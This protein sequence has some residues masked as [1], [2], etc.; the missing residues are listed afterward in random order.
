MAHRVKLVRACGVR[1]VSCGCFGIVARFPPPR[2]HEVSM[3]SK[4]TP[5]AAGSAKAV[6][7][8][9]VKRAKREAEAQLR[10]RG[11]QPV[12]EVTS[13]GPATGVVE[14]FTRRSVA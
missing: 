7:R 13:L 10:R 8:R 11:W 1:T 9:G 3:G 4:P 5:S 12:R 2:R 14:E 6:V